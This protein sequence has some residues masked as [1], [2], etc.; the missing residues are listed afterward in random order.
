MIRRIVL[1]LLIS[2]GTYNSIS[3]QYQ[4]KTADEQEGYQSIS[5]E[6]IYLHFND[7]FLLS[8]EYLYYKIYC[9]DAQ[10]GTQSAIS[11]IA[12]VQ[13]VGSDGQIVF[14]HKVKL[15][16]GQGQGE[17]FI[18]TAT[19]SGSYKLIGY[20]Q[21][22]RNMGQEDFFYAD[23]AIV[24]PYQELDRT[25]LLSEVIQSAD[26]IAPIPKGKTPMANLSK[27]SGRDYVQMVLSKKIYHKRELV[28]LEIRGDHQPLVKGNFS[29]S[30]RKLD[31]LHRFSPPNPEQVKL[32]TKEGLNKTKP[33]D[34]I[35]LPELRGE[36]ITGTVVSKE[37]GIP[38][39]N[40]KIAISLS[41]NYPVIKTAITDTN[42]RFFV[43]IDEADRNSEAQVLILEDNFNN[44]RITIDESDPIN[45]SDLTFKK[46]KIS[47][48][49]A[50]TIL[51]RSVH[52]Q[53]ESA[54]FHKRMDSTL[55][56][57]TENEFLNNLE[58]TYILNDYQRFSTL[59]E[60]IVEI[61]DNVW[62]KKEKD[63]HKIQIRG[64]ESFFV[65]SNEVPLVFV[66]GFF[67]QDINSLMEYDV[68]KIERIAV[69]RNKYYVGPQVYHGILSISISDQ[70]FRP[71]EN[72]SIHSETLMAPLPK[73]R[74]FFQGY[75]AGVTEV[76]R[77]YPD[78]RY[79]LLW[80]PNLRVE[81]DRTHIKFYTSDNV[82]DFEIV[83]QGFTLDG[84]PVSLRETIKVK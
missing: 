63:N 78:F 7:T 23:I 44:K 53:I 31:S 81:E 66:D 57:N 1:F 10:N 49:M 60:T 67:V 74:Y 70:N 42:G 9:L 33:G 45:Y 20:T 4:I 19:P 2:M 41:K 52:N 12:Y 55:T 18:P 35:F 21:W 11:K 65:A 32:N 29:L 27:Q 62:I 39:P 73:K 80:Q 58:E 34:Y 40:Q 8:G 61:L 22:M 68:K 69:S 48:E 75:G 82:G 64:T 76:Q 5:K 56:Q 36:L 24:N 79:Q 17:F 37:E 54:Y 13:L 30:V 59:K 50:K 16:S 38:Q 46:L 15:S 83:L 14:K 25:I 47:A 43:N 84:I 6:R 71:S 72:E 77:K 26:S 28:N 3:A 51:K